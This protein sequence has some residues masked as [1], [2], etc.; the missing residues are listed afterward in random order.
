MSLTVIRNILKDALKC[1]FIL[2]QNEV[3]WS[4]CSLHSSTAELWKK[5]LQDFKIPFQ[6]L[7]IV[8]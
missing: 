5:T 3:R 4:V 6:N 2:N 1:W 7:H 8:G